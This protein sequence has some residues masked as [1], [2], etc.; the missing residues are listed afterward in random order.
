M[1]NNR[2]KLFFGPSIPAL[3]LAGCMVGPKYHQPAATVQPPAAAYKELPAENPPAGQWKVAQ[4]QD[5]LLHGKWWEIY[6]DPELNALEDQLNINNQNIKVSFEN[7]MEARTLV[8]QA[9]AQLYPTL[10]TTPSFT[11]SQSSANLRNNVGATGTAGSGAANVY[12]TLTEVPF[13]A[14]WEPDVWGKVRNTIRNAQY[15]AQLSAADLENERL[16]EQASLAVFFFELRGQDAMQQI[17]NDTVQAD[18]KSVDLAR[19]RYETGVDTLLSLVEAQVTLQQAQSASTNLGIARAQF[20]HAI[21]V[22]VGTSASGF[23]MPYKPLNAAPPAIPVGIPTQLLERRPDIA[24]SE[25][26][27]AAANAQ[28]GIATAAYYPNLTLSAQGGFE[29]S[30]LQNLLTWP[31]RF[32][33]V[34]PSVSQSIFDAGL[35]RAT[36]NQFVAVYN[37]DVASYRQTV[38][39]AFQQVE[40]SLAEVRI[41]SAQIQQQQLAVE[42]AQKF[43]ELSLVRYETGV[44]TYL[45]VLVAQT[46]LLTDQQQLSSL[47]TLEMTS[48]VQLI[49]ALG[50]GWDHSQLPTPA[51][52]TKKVSKSEIQAPN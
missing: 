48:S 50:G 52:V 14:S 30:A 13:Q 34:G 31:S 33:S 12:S 35:R 46:T 39:T 10:G 4:P 6:S 17:L 1:N 51:Q 28:I 49:E 45:N 44:D 16:T 20:E 5:A 8:T 21:A 18:Q 42:S 26:A 22:L 43:L 9:R 11:R 3:L 36:V 25:R 40:D 29:S 41:L 24:A 37:A 32:W 38:L 23:S 2:L 19:A 7:F 47:Q 27:M 15:N